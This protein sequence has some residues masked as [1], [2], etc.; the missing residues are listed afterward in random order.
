M[1]KVAF[2]STFSIDHIDLYGRRFINT[3]NRFNSH[4]PL[5]IYA[6]N[7][8]KNI[9]DGHFTIFDFSKTIPEHITF[10][11]HIEMLSK[12]LNGKAINRYKKALRWSYKS[13]VILHA[14]QN[15]SFEFIVWLDGDVESLSTFDL[16]MIPKINSDSLV[17]LYPQYVKGELHIESGLL[18]FNTKHHKIDNLIRHYKEGYEK[19]KILELQKP[20]DGFW[21]AEFCQKNEYAADINYVRPPFAN[22]HKFFKHH[23]GKNKFQNLNFDKFSGRKT[24]T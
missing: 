22:L 6:E 5:Y 18:I 13:Y 21:L 20:W 2:I 3:F 4:I 17:T 12:G 7:F 23:V 1:D 11:D 16:S 9:V 19:Y 14:L 15:L 10:K 24:L 8:T